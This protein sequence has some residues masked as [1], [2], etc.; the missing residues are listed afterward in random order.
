[1]G[2]QAAVLLALTDEASPRLLMIRRS[3]HLSSHPGEIA[4]P[5]GKRDADDADDFA[6]ALRE[7]REEVALLSEY[8]SYAGV[9]IP[10][11]SLTDLFV[12]PIVGV[13]PPDLPLR[14]HPGE[15]TEILYVP[16]VF[17]A[18]ARNLRADRVRWNGEERV[19]ARFQFERYTIW[20]LSG[21]FIVQL[22]N[23]LYDA[24]LDIEARAQRALRGNAT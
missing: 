14:A 20:G 13:I 23:C 24:G 4:F 5:G 2:R 6:T 1:M 19:S 15:V 8:V 7:A 17:F 11:L 12:T 16:L 9:L 10:Q 22:V 18:D 21:R 3:L